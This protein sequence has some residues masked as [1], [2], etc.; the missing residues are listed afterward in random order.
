MSVVFP[1]TKKSCQAHQNP[2]MF[3]GGR[4]TG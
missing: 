1:K 4:A 3:C 2:A